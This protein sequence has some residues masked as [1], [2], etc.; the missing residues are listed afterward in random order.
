MRQY[1]RRKF[2]IDRQFQLKYM[3]LVVFLLLTY[4]GAFIVTLFIP[5][6]LPL[7]FNS[8]LQE[9]VRAA[10]ILLI[11]HK[12]IWPAL[13]IVIPLFGFASIFIT[14]NIAGPVYRL[15]KKLEQMTS[16]NFDGT[17]TLRKGDDLHDLAECVNNLSEELQVI[18]A[19]LKSNHTTI[20]D[21]INEIRQKIEVNALDEKTGREII[22]HLDTSRKTITDTLARFKISCS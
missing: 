9:Q 18:V 14:H 13:F 4:T 3:L 8:S 5:Q 6:I 15:K 12:N 21:N 10:E 11:Y 19:A 2:F 16:G 1:K 22:L 17:L 7:A 20:T